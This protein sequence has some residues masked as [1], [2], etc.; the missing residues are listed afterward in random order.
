MHEKPSNVSDQ[1]SKSKE[2]TK[3]NIENYKSFLKQNEKAFGRKKN[4]KNQ[5]PLSQ[6]Y[7]YMPENMSPIASAE[8]ARRYFSWVYF[9]HAGVPGVMSANFSQPDIKF[10]LGI[11]LLQGLI[12]RY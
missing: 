8:A 3:L 11:L 12:I 2:I 1:S 9:L 6:L 10:L 7:F 4:N 5:L